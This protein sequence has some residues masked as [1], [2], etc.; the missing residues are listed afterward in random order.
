MSSYLHCQTWRCMWNYF[1]VSVCLACL[2]TQ[3]SLGWLSCDTQAREVSVSPVGLFPMVL[4]ISIC[5]GTELSLLRLFSLPTRYWLPPFFH[6]L[7][8]DCQPRQLVPLSFESSTNVF[9]LMRIFKPPSK[10]ALLW[11][12][13]IRLSAW[14]LID[15]FLMQ[16]IDGNY[17]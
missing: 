10:S 1:L 6:S 9:L 3:S 14:Q 15:M 12:R 8:S 2:T 5:W 11:R 4:L 16:S 17:L 7:Q 13:H